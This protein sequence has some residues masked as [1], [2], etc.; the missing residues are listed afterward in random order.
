MINVAAMPYNVFDGRLG[1]QRCAP[2]RPLRVIYTVGRGIATPDCAAYGCEQP[3]VDG[4][5]HIPLGTP[6]Q[7]HNVNSPSLGAVVSHEESMQRWT[8]A[9]TL[10]AGRADEPKTTTEQVGFFTTKTTVSLGDGF[11]SSDVVGYVTDGGSHMLNADRG[12]IDV[13]ETMLKFALKVDT[14]PAEMPTKHV[15]T[16]H[17]DLTLPGYPHKFDLFVPSSTPRYGIVFLHG[18]G[19]SKNGTEISLGLTV[20]WAEE[21]RVVV[22]VPQ[23]QSVD[24]CGEHEFFPSYICVILPLLFI[25][26]RC[27]FS[28]SH[29]SLLPD[30]VVAIVTSFLSL[31]IIS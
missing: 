12:D 20:Q 1:R 5:G 28:F 24:T 7:V 17:S 18:G 23:G 2:A 8:Q 19:G 15:P 4:D 10:L 29:S 22:A 14:P 11:P 16:K 3:A 26:E 9:N 25:C 6:G 31:S 13:F 21:H 30:F 27:F